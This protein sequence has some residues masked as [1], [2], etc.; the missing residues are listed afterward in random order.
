MIPNY[1]HN[2]RSKRRK[3]PSRK[4]ILHPDFCFLQHHVTYNVTPSNVSTSGSILVNGGMRP[5]V[6]SRVYCQLVENLGREKPNH[7][8]AGRKRY[9]KKARPAPCRH[10]NEGDDNKPNKC[11]WVLNFP[12][13]CFYPQQKNAT[14]AF[15][16]P[17]QFKP[18][19]RQRGAGCQKV[20]VIWELQESSAWRNQSPS[21][22]QLL[23]VCPYQ[24]FVASLPICSQ[25]DQGRRI[26]TSN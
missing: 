26:Y 20:Q 6:F 22:L 3:L 15:Y 16:L 23:Y 14:A 25:P 4:S 8:L 24:P 18:N 21:A 2:I 12:P 5:I 1:T 9:L 11:R 13:L 17:F 10:S 7:Q 19:K